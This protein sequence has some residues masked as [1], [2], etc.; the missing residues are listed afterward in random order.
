[1]P[2]LPRTILPPGGA[3]EPSSAETDGCRL[4]EQAIANLL[5]VRWTYN[6]VQMQAEPH[7][8]YQKKNGVYLDAIVTERAGEAPA[9]IRL[10]SFKITGLTN[11]AI[12]NEAFSPTALDLTNARYAE[13]VLVQATN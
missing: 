6:R 3:K 5:C 1:M 10:G 2:D 13:G 8:L 9:E 12:V 11:L 7:I 4:L